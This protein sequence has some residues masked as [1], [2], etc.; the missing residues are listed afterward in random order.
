MTGSE[1][2]GVV[3]DG[4][5][6]PPADA[7][8]PWATHGVPPADS[9]PPW[10]TPTDVP[11][12]AQPGLPGRP[13]AGEE[14]PAGAKPK[15]AAI[16]RQAGVGFVLF[17]VT[18]LVYWLLGPF[19]T[20]YDFQLSQA[21]NLI[22]GH[23]DMT[24]QY[25][26]NL[27]ILERVL[28]DGQ[29][30]CLPLNDP[31]GP[32]HDALIPNARFSADCRHYMQHSLGPAFMLVP[33]VVLFGPDISQTLISA[34][35]GA[36]TAVIVYA[37]TRKFT[38]D[39]KTQLALTVMAMFGTTLWY[40]A[41]DGSVWHFAHATSVMFM[42]G[43][44]W[45][46]VNRRNALLAGALV[47]AAFMCRPST[48]LAGL[49]PLVAFA[50]MWLVD[51]PGVPLL[52]RLRLRPLLAM[53]AGVAPFVLAT[54]AV[55]YLRFNNPFET[56]YSLSEQI[57]QTN[58]SSV[59]SNGIFDISYISRHIPVVFE[60]MPIFG[61]EGS[62]VWPSYGGTAL[63]LVSPALLLAFFVHLRRYR[64]VALLGALALGLSAAVM[65]FAS[66]GQR[67]GIISWSTSDLPFGLH[68]LPFW[69][70]IGLAIALAVGL[71]DRIAVAAWVAIVAIAV[72][73]WLFAATGW[74]QF[75]YRYGLDFMPFL[76][77]LAVMAVP[78]IKRWH[79]ALIGAAVLVNLWGILWVVKFGP[80]Q[81]FGWTW[82][83]W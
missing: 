27:T 29:G 13:A 43:A 35:V 65:L 42:F 79:V 68:L 17:V 72:A 58:L 49:F 14:P 44:I 16:G 39:L 51:E 56:G 33:L 37:I 28:Y 61:T 6:V 66:F 63:W 5:R 77:L 3:R 18:F 70:L 10:A 47:G 83:G 60:Y 9:N 75:G 30:F 62:F 73:D 48:I 25:T 78:R 23:L 57:Y 24:E 2:T 7:D 71:R 76:W 50:D 11:P 40:S 59:Y 45:A 41:S 1:G 12:W 53:A 4:R 36:F 81:L 54:G 34:L 69:V 15:R 20:P 82:V 38:S 52:R 80:A 26:K 8:P 64:T 19:N 46:T 22:H 32:E 21:N 74:A 67:L 55:N 31:R